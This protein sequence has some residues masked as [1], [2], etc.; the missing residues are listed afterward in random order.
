MNPNDI[1]DQQLSPSDVD[2][3]YVDRM[4][5]IQHRNLVK[6]QKTLEEAEVMSKKLNLEDLTSSIGDFQQIGS[7]K[8]TPKVKRPAPKKKTSEGEE[9]LIKRPR[10]RPKR[11]DST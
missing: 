5:E 2:P 8:S 7:A 3:F 6:E 11:S 1:L 9:P 4:A 10:G